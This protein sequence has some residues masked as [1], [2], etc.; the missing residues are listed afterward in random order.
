MR[1]HSFVVVVQ[2]AIFVK[3][4]KGEFLFVE[5]SLSFSVR[6][7]ASVRRMQAFVAREHVESLTLDLTP[8]PFCFSFSF[9]SSSSTALSFSFF[10]KLLVYYIIDFLLQ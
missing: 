1:D 5:T 6:M 3:R 4:N 9:S 10:L 2:I 7:Q 8:H